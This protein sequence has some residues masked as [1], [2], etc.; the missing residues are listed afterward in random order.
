[1]KKKIVWLMVLISS[2]L[3]A[4]TQE[5][6]IR[7][8]GRFVSNHNNINILIDED[9]KD[10]KFS[11]MIPNNIS[12]FDLLRLFKIS[13][14]KRGFNFYKYGSVYYLSKKQ[15]FKNKGYI[16]K[17][18]YNSSKDC[19]VLLKT[20]GIKYSYLNDVNSFVISSTKKDFENI[21]SF[22]SKVDILK[23]QVMLKIMIF[24]FNDD[25]TRERG[26]QFGSIYKDITNST[27]TAINSIIA[28]INTS[29]SPMSSNDFYAAIRLLNEDKYINVKQYPYILAKNNE[30]FKF[31]A[32]ENIP[33]LVSSTKTE[34]TNTSEQNTI[35]Y[36]DVGL[37]ING[38]SFIY[39]NYINLDIDLVIED[40]LSTIVDKNGLTMPQTYKRV[41]KSNTNI[42]Y[43]QVLLLSGLKRIKHTKDEY[44]IPGLSSI[45]YLG[46]AFKFKTTNDT[47][48]NITIAIEVI[49]TNNKTELVPSIS[50]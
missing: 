44:S 11:I 47:T 48:L 38:K 43:N 40:L 28:S 49:K 23:Q 50:L 37:K 33:Y 4:N 25:L 13:V 24:E 18:K 21:S 35:E 19:E 5:L 46:E 42:K 16:Y 8:F 41:L 3:I 9:F 34:A 1:M 10:N 31:E 30:I 7:D 20:L 14:S 45:P 12:N 39:S 36:K 32:V 22:L 26:V 27:Q 2:A 15:E 6:S 29:N 17:L